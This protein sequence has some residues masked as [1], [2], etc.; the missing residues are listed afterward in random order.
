ME[1]TSVTFRLGQGIAVT[2]SGDA[3]DLTRMYNSRLPMQPDEQGCVDLGDIHEPGHPLEGWTLDEAAAEF[4]RKDAAKSPRYLEAEKAFHEASDRADGEA[5]REPYQALCAMMHPY[6]SLSVMFTMQI[7]SVT[8]ANESQLRR[9]Q[10]RLIA[11]RRKER[12]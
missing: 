9:I 12:A 1:I 5:M 6:N 7:E 11:A 4:S 2:I 3:L 8:G 10:S